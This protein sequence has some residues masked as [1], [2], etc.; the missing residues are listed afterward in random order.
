V[1]FAVL[2]RRQE[3]DAGWRARHAAIRQLVEQNFCE[4]RLAVNGL[5]QFMQTIG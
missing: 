4:T 2:G 3:T 1:A 5:E